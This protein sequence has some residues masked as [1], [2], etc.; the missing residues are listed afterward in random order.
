MNDILQRLF[1]LE[2]KTALVTGSS[3]GIGQ[4][5]AVALAEAGAFVAVHGHPA[6][7]TSNN[8]LHG[9]PVSAFRFHAILSPGHREAGRSASNDP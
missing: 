9:R 3:S 1:S 6:R 4:R 7:G 8:G 2:G 5:L